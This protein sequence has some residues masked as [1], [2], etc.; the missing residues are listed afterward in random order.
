[1]DIFLPVLR[2]D[3]KASELYNHK[4]SIPLNIPNTTF[5]GTT[6]SNTH[7]EI[8]Q[9]NRE[10][11]GKFEIHH[12]PFGHFFIFDFSPDLIKIIEDTLKSK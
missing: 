8:R 11:T 10:T 7:D 9:W 1:M 5:Y 12:F 3:F 4:T 2:V 6:D